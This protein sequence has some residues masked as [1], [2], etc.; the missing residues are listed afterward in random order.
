[1]TIAGAAPAAPGSDP[2][3]GGQAAEDQAPAHQPG[4]GSRSGPA[5]GSDQ[6]RHHAPPFSWLGGDAWPN[7]PLWADKPT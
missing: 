7:F 4:A 5:P 2:G 3:S 1:M 6:G